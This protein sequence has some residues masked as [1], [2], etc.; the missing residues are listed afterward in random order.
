MALLVSVLMSFSSVYRCK[1]MGSPVFFRSVAASSVWADCSIL[2]V[3][4]NINPRSFVQIEALYTIKPQKALK[5]SNNGT[6]EVDSG[7]KRNI[8]GTKSDTSLNNDKITVCFSP[9]YTQRTQ[10]INLCF[11]L[12]T[13]TVYRQFRL[14]HFLFT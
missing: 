3:F 12:R 6:E 13:Q 7:L 10:P 2:I 11:K 14:R 8:R 5:I 4:I 1:P 9:K